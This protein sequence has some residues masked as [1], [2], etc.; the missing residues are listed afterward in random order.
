MVGIDQAYANAAIRA[1]L[2][3]NWQLQEATIGELLQKTSYG[4]G[5]T[6][7]FDAIPE[8]VIS[9]ELKRFDPD[10]VFLTEEIGRQ[11]K[12]SVPQEIELQPI[13]Y[14]SDPTDRS[15][16][17]EK[18]LQGFVKENPS[19]I[20]LKFKEILRNEEIKERWENLASGPA[21]ITGPTGSISGIKK[22][23]PF[24]AV[25]VNYLTQDLFVACDWGKKRFNIEG[26]SQEDF[27]W[28]TLEKIFAEGEEIIF[29]QERNLDVEE[30]KKFFT[31]IGKEGYEENLKEAKIFLN[32]PLDYLV[33]KE[34]GGPTR[35]LYLSSLYEGEVGFILS[36]GEKIIEWIHWLPFISASNRENKT[37]KIFEISFEKPW[38]KNGILMATT[39]A[40]SIFVYSEKE[41][42]H[43]L[44]L[45]KLQDYPNPSQYRSC[46][47]VTNEDNRWAIHTMRQ[48][49]YRELVFNF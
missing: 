46:L 2:E 4:K 25:I 32:Q 7:G 10:I 12:F 3:A 20:D 39:I 45:V 8:I 34:P 19:F 22:G 43:L 37:L 38:T 5:D 24:F 42:R 40:Y 28:I 44:N 47:L 48:R 49:Q 16:F 35:I 26:I 17:L 31:F 14:I 9:E 21:V 41:K 33:Y 6:K 1:L 15:S 18:F 11:R 13:L 30:S 27:K 29:D 36:N 23:V